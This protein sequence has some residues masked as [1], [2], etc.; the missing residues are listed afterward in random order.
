VNSGCRLDFSRSG[1]PARQGFGD[2]QVNN[3][4]G[5]IILILLS[6]NLYKTDSPAHLRGKEVVEIP[7]D[8]NNRDIVIGENEQAGGNS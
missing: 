5:T 4:S 8:E 2:R 6:V 3:C 1:A 7:G